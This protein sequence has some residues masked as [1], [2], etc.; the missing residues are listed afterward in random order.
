MES[1]DA[2]IFNLNCGPICHENVQI[3]VCAPKID[4]RTLDALNDMQQVQ[5]NMI[6]IAEVYT[7]GKKK[8]LKY[9]LMPL[10]LIT[11]QDLM[12][13]SE[14]KPMS[15]ANI[16][17]F[18]KQMLKLMKAFSGMIKHLHPSRIFLNPKN[19][20]DEFKVLCGDESTFGEVDLH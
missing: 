5:N 17:T 8:Y 1:E 11:V 12:Q 3:G 7:V 14:D 6:K 4:M 9:E 15:E 13:D 2:V 10:N 20:E 18:V 19:L 16:C